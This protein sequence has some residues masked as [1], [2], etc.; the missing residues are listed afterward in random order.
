M[1]L[2]SPK[3]V[4]FTL[5]NSLN[6]HDR[7]SIDGSAKALPPKWIQF[8]IGL[9]QPFR[10][11]LDFMILMHSFKT[12]NLTF[13]VPNQYVFLKLQLWSSCSI[14]TYYLVSRNKSYIIWK[15][16]SPLGIQQHPNHHASSFV[17]PKQ[18]GKDRG[19]SSQTAAYSHYSA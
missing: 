18:R 4:V 5:N 17:S 8:P 10:D 1:C 6:S 2:V 7:F 13:K 14:V 19:A 9:C 3:C 11:G 12:I 15:L 16:H